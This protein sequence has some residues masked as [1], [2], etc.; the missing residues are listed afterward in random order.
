MREAFLSCDH[1]LFFWKSQ[2]AHATMS[3]SPGAAAPSKVRRRP[4]PP[5][6]CSNE[7]FLVELGKLFEQQ[8]VKQV[9]SVWINSK[10]HYPQMT[11]T[12]KQ[13][14]KKSVGDEDEPVA[15]VRASDGRITIRTRVTAAQLP[16]F[17]EAITAVSRLHMNNLVRQKRVRA[18]RQEEAT[19]EM[20]R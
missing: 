9:G 11:G 13:R 18:R 1:K 4:A 17:R 15:L 3:E 10:R 6:E 12:T 19:R 20:E 2:A 14:R 8:K 16:E 7:N 5:A